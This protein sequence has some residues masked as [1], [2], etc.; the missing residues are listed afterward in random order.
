MNRDIFNYIKDHKLSS[1][2]N[3]TKWKEMVEVITS[4]DEYLPLVNIKLIFDADSNNSFSPV[5]WHEVEK[6]GFELIEWI[7]IKP[8]KIEK[9]GRLIDPK[10]TDYT[11]FIKSGLDKHNVPYEH[12]GELF[13]IYGYR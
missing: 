11:E 13:T 6:N 12:E 2:M 9:S 10:I 5:W 4:D 8:F 7:Q 1:R 3:N